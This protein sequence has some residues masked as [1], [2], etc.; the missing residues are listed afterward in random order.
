MNRS[1]ALKAAVLRW[2]KSAAVRDNG[3]AKASTPEQRAAAGAEGKA[4]RLSI[5]QDRR[6][7]REERDKLD[8]CLW[9]SG[10]YRYTDG[11]ISTLGPFSA[12]HVRGQGDTWEEAFAKADA[13]Y[14]STAPKKLAA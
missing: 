8:D 5:P 7:T 13:N 3:A 14:P 4:L 11:N 1:Q 2:G 9:R 10:M 12:F 6:P